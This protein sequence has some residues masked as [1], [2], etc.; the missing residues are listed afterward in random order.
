M[1]ARLQ[2][3]P[4]HRTAPPGTNTGQSFYLPCVLL[5]CCRH[6]RRFISHCYRSADCLK[7]TLVPP[8]YPEP[9]GGHVIAQPTQPF[10]SRA[11]TASISMPNEAVSECMRGISFA[12][13]NCLCA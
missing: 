2:A 6:R 9:G 1:T 7:T 12:Q 13:E 5:C 11:N 8:L 10:G 3:V 4:Q